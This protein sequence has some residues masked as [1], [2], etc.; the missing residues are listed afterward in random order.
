LNLDASP[1]GYGIHIQSPEN[2]ASQI[3]PG[4]PEDRRRL[5][6]LRSESHR[7]VVCFFPVG[8]T[9]WTRNPRH[10]VHDLSTPVE[11]IRPREC[12]TVN[13]HF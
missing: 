13:G 4:D 1:S 11:A 12:R 2:D 10:A 5:R 8:F 7:L 6:Y 9:S 3:L